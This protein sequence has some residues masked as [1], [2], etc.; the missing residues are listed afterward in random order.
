MFF[1]DYFDGD[2]LHFEWNKNLDL[3]YKRNISKEDLNEFKKF[4]NLK[5]FLNS[6]CIQKNKSVFLKESGEMFKFLLKKEGNL[7]LLGHK[8]TYDDILN[9]DIKQSE[10]NVCKKDDFLSNSFKKEI[11][12][13]DEIEKL[14]FIL[15][16]QKKF[17]KAQKEIFQN[18]SIVDPVTMLYNRKYFYEKLE[19][20][21]LKAKA[22]EYK[23]MKTYLKV[24]NLKE[25]NK[26]KGVYYADDILKTISKSIKKRS[27]KDLDYSFRIGSKEF[28]I[29]S[30]DIDIKDLQIKY[31]DM[32]KELKN[33]RNIDLMMNINEIDL[34]QNLENII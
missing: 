27:R 3:V 30:K 17:I 21:L 26:E 32:A 18:I 31:D 12:L 15:K 34:E 2:F 10:T 24:R 28:I 11:S 14:Q 13:N 22:F 9:F 19:S 33:K 29:I 1:K 23:I 6:N 8:I 16:K 4:F 20:E 25:L 5:D 7:K